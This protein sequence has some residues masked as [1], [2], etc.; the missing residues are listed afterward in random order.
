MGWLSMDSLMRL[1]SPSS[2]GEW[3]TL[4]SAHTRHCAPWRGMRHV[5]EIIMG[6]KTCQA[7]N[8]LSFKLQQSVVSMLIGEW[9]LRLEKGEMQP[10]QVK[11]FSGGSGPRVLCILRKGQAFQRVPLSCSHSGNCGETSV[12]YTGNFLEPFITTERER[13]I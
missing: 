11:E 2:R 10:H 8:I 6:Y 3:G 12:G 9:N 13:Q 7:E 5:W 4:P 1:I